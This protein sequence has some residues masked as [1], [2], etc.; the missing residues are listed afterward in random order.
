MARESLDCDTCAV[1]NRAACAALSGDERKELAR[2]GHHRTLERG[3]TLFTSG[4]DNDLCAT[5]ISGVL[6]VSSFDAE[7]TEHIVSLIHP[8][9]FVGELFT[10]VAHHD[11]IA[12]TDCEVC[13]FPRERYEQALRRFPELAGALLRRSSQELV[14]SRRLLGSITGRRA[15][16]RLASLL[17]QL[18]RAA[19]DAECHEARRFDLVLTRGEMASLL[20][21]TIETVSRQLTKLERDGAIA[22]EGARA[23]WIRDAARLGLLAA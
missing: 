8:A 14:D 2:I 16:Q 6:K 18:A 21:L 3:E 19:S 5:L 11:T 4:D 13:V 9:G 22:R 17:L 10:P 23:I 12:V 1:R 20:G 7:G 15:E